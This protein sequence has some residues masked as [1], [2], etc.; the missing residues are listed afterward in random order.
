MQISRPTLHTHTYALRAHAKH[1]R[2]SDSGA[3][4]GLMLLL[5]EGVLSGDKAL[6]DFL[7]VGEAKCALLFD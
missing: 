3:I 1:V 2:T 4:M 5:C 7:T 6:L